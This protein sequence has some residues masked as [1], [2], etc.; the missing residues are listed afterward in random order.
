MSQY[1]WVDDKYEY[2]AGFD[3]PLKYCF[4]VV[5]LKDEPDPRTATDE[6]IEAVRVWSNLDQDNPAMTPS[7]VATQVSR[8]GGVM[9][10]GDFERMANDF[11]VG[12]GVD[13]MPGWA[14]EGLGL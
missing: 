9:P 3:E 8:M 14:K 4:L 2:L 12:G 11:E 6:E 10:E 5:T 13:K 7:E 1:K